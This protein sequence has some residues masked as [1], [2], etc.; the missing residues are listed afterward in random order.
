MK[1]IDFSGG[2][3]MGYG[4]DP[5]AEANMLLEWFLEL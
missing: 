5:M 2:Y 1:V 4:K 3:L